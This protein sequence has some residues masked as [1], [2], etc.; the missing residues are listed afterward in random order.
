M[1]N[2]TEGMDKSVHNGETESDDYSEIYIVNVSDR[3]DGLYAFADRDDA[4]AFCDK[5]N[6]ERR[7][8]AHVV[9]EDVPLNDHAGTL[10][11]IDAEEED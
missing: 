1:S 2:P 7:P 6:K 9:P 4:Q 5:V 3:T 10:V 11:L 8:F